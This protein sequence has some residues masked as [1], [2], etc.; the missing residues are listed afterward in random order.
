[1]PGLNFEATSFVAERLRVAVNAASF[2]PLAHAYTLSVSVG[3][4]AFDGAT[5][6]EDLY[7]RADERLFKAKRA[8][9][10]RADVVPLA[11]AA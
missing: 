4:T 10:N 5:T 6:F 9:R 3:G 11:V 1:M 7:R 8:G 2:I